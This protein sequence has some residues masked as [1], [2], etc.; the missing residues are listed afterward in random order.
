[1]KRTRYAAF[2]LLLALFSGVQA[3]DQ[4]ATR[5]EVDC[6]YPMIPEG[7]EFTKEL[8]DY[9]YATFGNKKGM[10]VKVKL[11]DRNYVLIGGFERNLKEY[12]ETHDLWTSGYYET[13]SKATASRKVFILIPQAWRNKVTSMSEKSFTTL[14]AEK[15]RVIRKRQTAHWQVSCGGNG[16]AHGFNN[17][18]NATRPISAAM[19]QVAVPKRGAKT[20][21]TTADLKKGDRI[22]YQGDDDQWYFGKMGEI[23]DDVAPRGCTITDNQGG[24]IPGFL[25]MESLIVHLT[26]RRRTT[27]N[28][29]PAAECAIFSPKP[30]LGSE[31]CI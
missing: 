30:K 1:M 3:M 23:L 26:R 31:L 2:A 29:I 21:R 15:R 10:S 24:V 27:T 13:G 9:K 17:I 22:W 7:F 4:E 11:Y 8:Q 28:L 6:I 5:R 25:L 16:G 20:A 14:R 18:G 12:S 19:V